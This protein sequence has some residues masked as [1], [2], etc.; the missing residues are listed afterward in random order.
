MLP[1]NDKELISKV[2][3][4]PQVMK[5]S[6]VPVKEWPLESRWYTQRPTA[7]KR[8]ITKWKSL[9]AGRKHAKPTTGS[10]SKKTGDKWNNPRYQLILLKSCCY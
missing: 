10:K 2:S 4:L 8:E 5:T 7:P 1:A 3:E 9:W 6:L